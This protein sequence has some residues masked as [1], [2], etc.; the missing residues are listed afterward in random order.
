M[1]VFVLFVLFSLCAAQSTPPIVS[2]P[3]GPIQGYYDAGSDVTRFT[4]IPFA[5]PPVGPL[6]FLPPADPN[7]TLALSPYPA[8]STNTIECVA[9]YGS[10]ALSG[11]EDC[12]YLSI[13]APNPLPAANA[14]L[15]VVVSVCGGG[16]QQ[17]YGN[18]AGGWLRRTQSFIFVNINYRLGI[19]GF[20]ALQELSALQS[21]I[22]HSGNQ[23]LQDQQAALRWVRDN[24]ASF[25]GDPSKVTIQGE[26]AGSI[27]ICY[28]LI[29][30][31]SAGLVP[32][33]DH[34]EWRL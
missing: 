23:G 5:Q 33:C 13:T 27:S 22:S 20:F 10:G 31:Q 15:P 12:L 11:Q 32:Q 4:N 3:A 7:A 34:G 17:C 19:F 25:G 14:G 8:N 1:L 6:R 2:T 28:H 30:P 16:F 26:S 9:N 29:A 18:D 24:I 21:P